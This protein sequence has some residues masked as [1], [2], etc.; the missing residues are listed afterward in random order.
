MSDKAKILASIAA[1]AEIY[2]R[3][4]SP[5][6][7]ELYW[8]DLRD[9]DYPA[10]NEALTL[11]RK[12]GAAFMASPGQLREAL[13]GD[14]EERA[15]RAWSKFVRAVERVGA[16]R[17]PVFDDP[18]I[19]G[20]I[21]D[22]GGWVELCSWEE[23]E[24]PFLR[25]EFVSRYKARLR[26]PDAVV[27]RLV[28]LCERDNAARFPAYVDPPVLVGDADQAAETAGRLGGSRADGEREWRRLAEK[29]EG[30]ES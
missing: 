13:E 20:V 3:Q 11:W 27:P 1:T 22:M 29:I 15:L 23:R 7:L 16:Y 12:S 24:E 18:A 19:H 21:R 25:K 26:R 30:G 5:A 17:T 2:G 9:L 6:A 28:G 4:L 10:V 14:P 8:L